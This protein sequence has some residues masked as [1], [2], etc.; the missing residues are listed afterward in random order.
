MKLSLLGA[1]LGA[2]LVACPVS[3]QWLNYKD[4]GIPRLPSGRPNLEAAAPR[5]PGGKPDLSG[6]WAAECGL[7]GADACFTK[8]FFFD[9]AKDLKPEEVQ[10]TPWAA[11]VSAQ[12]AGRNHVD[13]PYGYC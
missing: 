7:Y 2:L 13:D 11:G 9:L 8:S 5:L 3:G 12:R 10:M 1:A 4:R 6:V